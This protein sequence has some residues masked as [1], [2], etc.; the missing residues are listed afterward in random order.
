MPP[1]RNMRATSI[2]FCTNKP[3]RSMSTNAPG[4]NTYSLKSDFDAVQ[5]KKGISFGLGRTVIKLL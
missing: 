2:G 5:N 1:V 4:P 3:Q